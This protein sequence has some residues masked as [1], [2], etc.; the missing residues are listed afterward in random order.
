MCSLQGIKALLFALLRKKTSKY[1]LC[2]RAVIQN[3]TRVVDGQFCKKNQIAKISSVGDS[4]GLLC[5][6][7]LLAVFQIDSLLIFFDC[8]SGGLL[9]LLVVGFD[10]LSYHEDNIRSKFN[11]I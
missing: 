3:E 8:R 1:Y 6:K 11:T 9:I 10:D 4:S 7:L 5:T 2:R